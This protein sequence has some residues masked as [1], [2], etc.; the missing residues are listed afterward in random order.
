MFSYLSGFI[1]EID[2]DQRA[3]VYVYLLFPQSLAQNLAQN[4]FNNFEPLDSRNDLKSYLESYKDPTLDGFGSIYDHYVPFT[5]PFKATY[6]RDTGIYLS[7]EDSETVKWLEDNLK[8]NLSEYLSNLSNETIAKDKKITFD[9]ILNNL[10]VAL[11]HVSF[12]DNIVQDLKTDKSFMNGIDYISDF[13]Y[14]YKLT[15]TQNL[16]LGNDFSLV[17][18]NKSTLEMIMES[19]DLEKSF[20]GAEKLFFEEAY[21]LASLQHLMVNLNKIYKPC[22]RGGQRM[23]QKYTD[24]LKSAQNETNTIVFKG[25][26]VEDE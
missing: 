26:G 10:S 1:S 22:N 23:D 12:V 20:K 24:L 17:T 16:M 3:E 4:M 25:Y 11:E 9:N 7:D 15:L 13:Y 6:V 18:K 5:F 21:R 2:F 19:E 14:F 8:I